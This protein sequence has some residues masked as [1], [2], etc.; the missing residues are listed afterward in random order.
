MANSL[1]L[2]CD[3]L[4]E[5]TYFD[6]V[7]S[8]E[9][10]RPHTRPNAICLHEED[11][12]ILWK[13]ADMTSG[14]TEV[15]RSRRLVVSSIATVGN[16]EYGFY[17]Y[18][19][20]DGTMQ[21][22]VKLT[23]IMSTMG[24]AE[25]VGDAHASLVAPG[26]AA[27]YHQHMFNVRLDMEIDGNDNAVFEV[28]TLRTPLGDDNPWGNAFAP[29]ATL[30]ESESAAGRDVDPRAAGSG[31]SSTDRRSTRG[32]ATA[33]NSSRRRPRLARRSVVDRGPA[34]DVRRAQLVGDAVR[35]GRAAGRG[36]LPESAQWRGRPSGLDGAGPLIVDT[37][38]VLWHSFGVTHI[39]R[40]ED[41][42]VMPVE[43][44][45]FSLI[46]V[47]SSIATQRST[48]RRP[49]WTPR[50][51]PWRLSRGRRDRRRCWGGGSSAVCVTVRLVADAVFTVDADDRC[52]G[53]E[54][55]SST[56][57]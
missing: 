42:P 50:P 32:T 10:G 4:G 24:V 57:A 5:I 55:S 17:W 53:P 49:R 20:L 35:R 27:P 40:P 28:D 45:G 21:F 44:T 2:G 6:D 37:D 9:R 38:V 23:G 51:L 22:E 1:S 46:P 34:G 16:Y 15:R 19:Y 29:V 12:G 3:C 47:A 31:R 14:R 25:G 13:H 30:L 18:F 52:G 43:Y 36:R 11:Y 26:L 54:R 56:P 8:D 41:W 48:Y 7:F 33:Y 39:P